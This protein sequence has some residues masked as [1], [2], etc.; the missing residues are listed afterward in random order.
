V[1]RK[2]PFAAIRDDPESVHELV[3]D[4]GV[5]IRDLELANDPRRARYVELPAILNGWQPPESLSP[6]LDRAIAA[7]RSSPAS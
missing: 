7:L 4:H 6:A 2:D 3:T 1:L 5:T